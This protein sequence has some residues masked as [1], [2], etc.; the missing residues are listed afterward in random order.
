MEHLTF[1]RL[2]WF[3]ANWYGTCKLRV[4]WPEVSDSEAALSIGAYVP[5][6]FRK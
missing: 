3:K 5:W 4:D 6:R 1:R 2:D